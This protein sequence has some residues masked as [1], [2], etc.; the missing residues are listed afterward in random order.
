MTRYTYYPG[1]TLKTTSKNFEDSTLATAK[2]LGIELVEP[3]RWNCC[4]TVYALATDD[5]MHHL[6]PIR[7]M[8]R[9]EELK[10]Q[11][12]VDNKKMITLCAMCYNTL[13]RAN[14]I[15]NTDSDKKKKIHE[16]MFREDIQYSGSVE[17]LHY[18][19]VLRELGWDKAFGGIKRKKDETKLRMIPIAMKF[20][21][22]DPI[23]I[24]FFNPFLY[25][26]FCLYKRLPFFY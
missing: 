19:E 12:K 16:I 25:I 23:V 5:V 15:F 2:A 13:K 20:F 17:I 9:V 21:L 11:G 3:D 18:L 10:E 22:G 1:C 7:N 8:I 4:G 6:A 24:I 26:Y 14:D